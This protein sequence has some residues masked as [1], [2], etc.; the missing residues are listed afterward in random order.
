VKKLTTQEFIDRARAV[1]GDKYGYAFVSYVK[2]SIGIQIHCKKHGLF[3][4]TPADHLSGRECLRCSYEKR[5]NKQS[6]NTQDF[7]EK[8]KRIHGE[9]YCYSKTLYESH[10]KKVNII[11]RIHGVFEQTPNSH[12]SGRGCSVCSKKKQYTNDS[13]IKKA[14]EVHGD[15]TY[16]YGLVEYTNCKN[17]VTI[18]CNVHG[19]FMQEASSHLNGVGCPGCA[20]TGFD[21]TS[22]GFLYVL[23]SECGQYMKI[24]I[25][26]KP[27]Q[28]NAQLS[29]S[30][31]FSFK[32]IELIEGSGELIANLE[33][34]LLAEYRPAEFTKTFDGYSEWRLW[35]DSIRHKLISF[36]NKE[37]TNGPI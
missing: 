24:G 19:S 2:N 34:E 7:I 20:K 5:R 14:R 22:I 17:K 37:L 15:D 9:K 25:T 36:M 35:D 6:S 10:S 27:D 18:I 32:R 23:R 26:N 8:S 28:R 4:Q 12:L 16:D 30:T 3:N 21:R 11:C 29:R 1:H 33:K 31:P 13:F